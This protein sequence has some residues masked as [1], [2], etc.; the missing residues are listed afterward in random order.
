VYS[1]FLDEQ[2]A[3]ETQE[4][5]LLVKEVNKLMLQL[6]MLYNSCRLNLYCGLKLFEIKLVCMLSVN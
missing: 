6:V 3:I 5:E 2:T 4:G 1:W